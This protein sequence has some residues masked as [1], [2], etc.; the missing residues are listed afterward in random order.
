MTGLKGFDEP[1]V[2]FPDSVMLS[3][4]LPIGI[5]GVVKKGGWLD[6]DAFTLETDADWSSRNFSKSVFESVSEGGLTGNSSRQI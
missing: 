3:L 4:G 6:A 2:G 1:K 5:W